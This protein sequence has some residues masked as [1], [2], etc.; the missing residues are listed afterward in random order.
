MAGSPQ[1][2]A[3]TILL[4]EDESLLRELGETILTQAGYKVVTAAGADELRKLVAES[5]AQVDLL[6]TDVL[7]PDLGGQELV[8]LAK[9]RWP[10]IRVLYMSGYSTE[11]LN[12]LERDAAF[13]QK[14]F[15][16]SELMAKVKE[17]IE[18]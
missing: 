17:L 7:M 12:D 4:A 5:P 10:G 2:T 8:A 16:P 1:S 18:N 11:D 6:L 9:R 15:T 14:P 13:L 3:A